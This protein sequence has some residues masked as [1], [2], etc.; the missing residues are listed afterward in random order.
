MLENRI[1]PVEYLHHPWFCMD[2]QI[3]RISNDYCELNA[4]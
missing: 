4:N 1:T 2:K 3:E